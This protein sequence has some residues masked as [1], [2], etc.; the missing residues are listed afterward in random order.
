MKN[1]NE[2]LP[3]INVMSICSTAHL[4][5]IIVSPTT[6]DIKFDNLVF[7]A[8]QVRTLADWQSNH[9]DLKITIQLVTEK[10]L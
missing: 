10:L 2:N 9:E 7:T 8:N 3:A 5:Q 6:T 4:K 1:Q